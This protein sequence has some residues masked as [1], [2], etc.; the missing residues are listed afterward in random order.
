MAADNLERIA[1]LIDRLGP[2][3]GK[4][5]GMR[6]EADEW[7]ALVE[8][9]QGLLQVER[10][11]EQTNASHLEER[12]ALKS[13]EHLGEVSAAW[14]DADLQ[15]KL[16]GGDGSVSTRSALAEISSR[17]A[18]LNT[19]V[20]RLTALLDSHG[21][22]IDRSQVEELDRSRKLKQFDDRFAGVENLR[23]LV[24]TL[25]NDVTGVKSNVDTVLQLRES[26]RDVTGA[27]IDVS[28]MRQELTDVQTLREN[29]KGVD[30]Q[31]LRLRDVEIKLRE[32]SDS[33]GVGGAGGLDARIGAIVAGTE[34]RLNTRVDERAAGLKSELD[35]TVVASENRLKG[36]L[37]SSVDSSNSTL[38]QSVIVQVEAAEGRITT[39]TGSRIAQSS[40]DTEGRA[41]AAT[42]SLVESKFALVPDQVRTIAT[43]LVNEARNGLREDLRVSLTE[44][45][46][47]RITDVDGR[48][49]GRADAVDTKVA[50]IEAS[51]PAIV[52]V[53]L[54]TFGRQMEA[55][56]DT[57]LAAGIERARIQLRDELGGVVR[58]SVIDSL[59]NLDSRI[60]A[61][62][63]DRLSGLD[64]R[65]GQAV[66]VATSNLSQDV[67]TEVTRQLVTVDVAGQISAANTTLAQQL[68]AEQTQAI[69]TAQVQNS[70]A[71]SNAVGL[72]RSE[73]TAVRT[74]TTGLLDTR[75][76]AERNALR[77]EFS[78][79]L[80]NLRGSLKPDAFASPFILTP[81]IRP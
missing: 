60:V 37:A 3:A 62:V 20:G 38:Q 49:S 10:V 48:L 50:A 54:N 41:L 34:Q 45:L 12:F 8:I 35:A 31:L 69:A 28:K 72:L 6:I 80:T 26:L 30:G 25:S 71:V 14:L 24:S 79:N 17:I 75:L 63:D 4:S 65:I 74:E 33:V 47:T 44:F 27:P 15:A 39:L 55:R 16:G 81:V 68:R 22:L 58:G 5:R 77:S 1:A 43:G 46:N 59:G 19:E 11:Q 76:S 7:N 57:N 42:T 13:H 51:V 21:K 32:I 40:A 9:L 66:T 70:A 53:Q 18:S 67:S 29:L 36:Q 52:D 73:I 2:L 23:T 78:T 61:T 56:L 64:A